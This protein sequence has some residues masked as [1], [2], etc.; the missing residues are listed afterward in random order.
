MKKI[1]LLFVIASTFFAC[2]ETTSPKETAQAFIKALYSGDRT[3]ASGYLSSDSKAVLDKAETLDQQ[4]VSPEESFQF[5]TLSE[6]VS[7]ETATV[8]NEAITI[9]LVKENDGWKVVLTEDLLTEIRTREEALSSVQKSWNNLLTEY[10]ARAG[11]ARDYIKYRKGLGTLSPKAATLS[12]LLDSSASPKDWN[13]ASL[14]A[15]VQN[16]EKLSAAIDGALEPSQTANT[17]LT[18]NYFVQFSNAGDRIK[19]AE[20]AYQATAEKAHSP[21]YVP[22]PGKAANSMQVKAD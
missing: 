1:L 10:E 19:A 12:S 15:Y 16:Q 7:G 4:T 5:A 21:L 3:T 14:L 13:K 9:P 20:A 22:L 2:K 8:K 11:V 6:T 17:D 18:M